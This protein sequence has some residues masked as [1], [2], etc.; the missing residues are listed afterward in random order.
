MDVNSLF[1][2]GQQLLGLGAVL[3]AGITIPFFNGRRSHTAPRRD[4]P[5]YGSE[6]GGPERYI[7]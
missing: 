7:P 2:T 4:F 6:F 5:S 3:L 1:A